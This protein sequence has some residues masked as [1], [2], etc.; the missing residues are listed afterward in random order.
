M[1]LS[2]N[3]VVISNKNERPPP[4]AHR[5]VRLFAFVSRDFANEA[6]GKPEGQ[7][8]R[9]S[10]SIESATAAGSVHISVFIET[11]FQIGEFLLAQMITKY[12]FA[13][14]EILVRKP[15]RHVRSGEWVLRNVLEKGHGNTGKQIVLGSLAARRSLSAPE[16]IV[17]DAP[18]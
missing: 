6:T 1:E 15:T 14:E 3:A 4:S 2:E 18:N 10:A 5:L 8:S 9:T 16:C 13:A 11:L 7:T 12:L 17:V